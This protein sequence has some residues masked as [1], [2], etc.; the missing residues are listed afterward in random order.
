LG[1]RARWHRAARATLQIPYERRQRQP[2]GNYLAL[3]GRD[4]CSGE[5]LVIPIA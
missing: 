5:L 1:F 2:A 4:C 3:S